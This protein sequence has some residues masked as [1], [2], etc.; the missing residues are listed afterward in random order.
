VTP[1][2]GRRSIPG[3]AGNFVG[4]GAV[5]MN[6][7]NRRVRDLAGCVTLLTLLLVLS[8]CTPSTVARVDV[9]PDPAGFRGGTSLEHPYVLP[10]QTL[11]DSSGQSF[12]LRTSPSKPALL[13]FFGYSH[14]PDVCNAVLADVASALT[15]LKN[16]D[17]D[18]IQ[19]V[20]V[21]TD[22][23]RDT[24][25]V[26]GKYLDRFDPDYIGLTGDLATIKAVGA[27]VGVDIEGM[28]KL[29]SGGYEVGHS[30]QVIGFDAH[31]KGVVFWTPDTPIGDLAH[32]FGLLID[33]S[34]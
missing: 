23:A 33:R 27:R 12:N 18:Q 30:A 19:L 6:V 15:R 16:G 13:V 1:A 22:P 26:I 9:Q 14:C 7:S 32:D 20:F 34:R 11:T 17:R 10:E 5:D 28:K 25:K 21:T 2:E 4:A 8:A 24:P 29:P 3:R 31:R